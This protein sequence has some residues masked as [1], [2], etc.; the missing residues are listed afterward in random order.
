MSWF[1]V[2]AEATTTDGDFGIVELR[3]PVGDASPLH[4][5]S[6]EDE[7][8][9]VL[10][11]ALEVQVGGAV[12]RLG[13][14]DAVRGVRGVPHGYRVLGDQPARFLVVVLPAGLEAAF[15]AMD[16]GDDAALAA[17]GVEVLGPLPATGVPTA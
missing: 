11:G 14:G 3:A 17:A 4:R 1:T 13:P 10:S 5:H 15:R 6:R 12:H 8:F 9:V 2:H 16:A 7:T